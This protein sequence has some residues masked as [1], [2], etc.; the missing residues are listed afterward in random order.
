MTAPMELQR[1]TWSEGLDKII[2]SLVFMPTATA[3]GKTA[4][5]STVIGAITVATSRA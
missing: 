3:N 4:P 5:N 2:P 1:E